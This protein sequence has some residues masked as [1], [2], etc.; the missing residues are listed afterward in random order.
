MGAQTKTYQ[1]DMFLNEKL[2]LEN[3]ALKE[4]EESTKRQLRL[5]HHMAHEATR[6]LDKQ[7]EL[8]NRLVD[9]ILTE[10]KTPE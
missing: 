1:F 9:Y 6:R 7:E 2:E 8:I 5:L 4:S 3:K 10:E